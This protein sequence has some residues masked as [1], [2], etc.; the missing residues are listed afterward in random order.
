MCAAS[1][2]LFFKI[3]ISFDFSTSPQGEEFRNDEKR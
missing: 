1:G 3:M 2:F